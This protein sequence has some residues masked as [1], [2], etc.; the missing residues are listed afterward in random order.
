MTTGASTAPSTRW[1]TTADLATAALVARLLVA[2]HA[3]AEPVWDGFYYD[4]GARR[5]A[6]GLGY[7]EDLV[8][9]GKT[10][11][12]PWAH[13]PVG[14]SGFLAG[15]YALLGDGLFVAAVANALTG[16]LLAAIVHRVAR[17]CFVGRGTHG[18]RRATIAGWLVALHPGLVLYS[19]ALMTEPLAALG[20]FAAIAIALHPRRILAAIAAGIVLGL[21][22]L[23]RPN[24][25]LLAPFLAV[26]GI[27]LRGR[28]VAGL[29]S[30][31]AR[32][33]LISACALAAVAPWTIRNCRVMDACTLVSTN[34]GW[35]LVI[36]AAPGA[37]G[38]FEFLV[39][40]IP[41]GAPR[42]DDGGQVAQDRCWARYGVSLI[43]RDPIRWL[44]LVP[45]KLHHTLDAEWFPINYLRE[46]RPDLVSARAHVT[47][48][49]V[50]TTLNA[51]LLAVAAIAAIGFTRPSRARPLEYA[52]Q[53]ALLLGILALA[54]HGLDPHQPQVWPLGVAAAILPFLPLPGAPRPN[55]ASLGVAAIALTTLLTH[56]IF[57]GEDR[58]HLVATPA[59]LL[60]AAGLGRA[61]DR[62]ARAPSGRRAT[63]SRPSAP[64]CD[65]AASRSAPQGHSNP[66]SEGLRSAPQF[67]QTRSG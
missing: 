8:V 42:C 2:I 44:G 54:L 40:N 34:A 16:A 21:T 30:F 43:R 25:I 12:L 9:A 59:Y 65:S 13:Y 58:Y 27:V 56:A 53:C 35:N 4:L 17:A 50:L 52:T 61:T 15:F 31:G 24:A 60:L 48:G 66:P 11:W 6:A 62:D 32:A 41:E 1:A 10:L 36:G 57:F 51:I 7:S 5:I 45:A 20:M 26:P 64:T 28:I 37:T 46:A 47:I 22:T 38:K 18:E 3:Q 29:A 23:V 55:A 67:T 49:K 33:A 39:G 63:T 19:G 14:Y